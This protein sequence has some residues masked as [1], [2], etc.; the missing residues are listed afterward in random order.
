MHTQADSVWPFYKIC[1]FQNTVMCMIDTYN[2]LP[3]KNKLQKY[4]EVLTPARL[5]HF[6]LCKMFSACSVQNVLYSLFID[7][8]LCGWITLVGQPQRTERVVCCLMQSCQPTRRTVHFILQVRKLGL[9]GWVFNL[10]LYTKCQL[11]PSRVNVTSPVL[12]RGQEIVLLL[13]KCDLLLNCLG[14][15]TMFMF[16]KKEPMTCWKMDMWYPPWPSG[17]C[18]SFGFPLFPEPSMALH[19]L[20]I[21]GKQNQWHFVTWFKVQDCFEGVEMVKHIK[22]LSTNPDVLSSILGPL[23][24]GGKSALHTFSR[25]QK[26]TPHLILSDLRSTISK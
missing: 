1:I 26:N 3:I 6:L 8:Q 13:E 14:E 25:A 23:M 10:K 12:H 17:S 2:C 18:H 7:Q 21:F 9:G 22:A 11:P 4:L 16:N 20:W 15:H 19:L 5:H 24:I